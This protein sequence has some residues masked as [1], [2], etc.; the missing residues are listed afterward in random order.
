MLTIGRVAQQTGLTP[1]ALR[2]YE[3]HGLIAPP[4]RTAA[5]YRTYRPE[6]LRV[7]R[8]IRRAQALGLTLKEIKTILDVQRDGGSPCALVAQLLDKHLAEAQRRIAEL[9]ELSGVLRT[10]RTLA[11][12]S[13]RAVSGTGEAICPAIEAVS[14]DLGLPC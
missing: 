14:R 2:L 6:D 9:Q 10:A 1:K 5:G 11:D 4:A 13:A 12:S 3:A 7:L 8:F